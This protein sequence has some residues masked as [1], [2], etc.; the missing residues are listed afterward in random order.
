MNK[1]I[2][3]AIAL[4][5]G[6]ATTASADQHDKTSLDKGARVV[7]VGEISSPPK[8]KLGEEKMQ[9][10]VGPNRTDYTLHFGKA[11][12]FGTD[13]RKLDEDGLHDK[14]W[15]RAEGVVMDD[16]RRVQ[17]DR[18]TVI[19][20]D[21]GQYQQSVFFRPGTHFGYLET[22]AGARE[23]LAA[24]KAFRKGESVVLI[25]E[26]ASPPKGVIGEEKMQVAIGPKRKE[27]T[28]HFDGA[29]ILGPGGQKLDEDGLDD[30][31][32]IRAEGRVMDDARRIK[33]TQIRVLGKDRN[34]FVSGPYFR[35]DYA[36]G[37]A[38]HAADATARVAGFRSELLPTGASTRG[39][40]TFVH[41]TAGYF[42]VRDV[43][44]KDHKVWFNSVQGQIM[45]NGASNLSGVSVGQTV[46]VYGATESR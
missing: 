18:L 27:Y 30:K 10:A 6:C 14:M 25:G 1:T 33:V 28:L 32:W 26:I 44:G 3:L 22:V 12:I 40:V 7:I 15:V 39:T 37:F 13:G 11:N 4:A 46:T 17:V 24:K 36:H 2:P 34:A 19:A 21:T 9:V 45:D 35:S 38:L 31:M 42:E 5:V 20:K 29:Q 16:S 41:P 43:E 23:T 8:G